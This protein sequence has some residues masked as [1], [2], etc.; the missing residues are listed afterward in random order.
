MRSLGTVTLRCDPVW[1]AI[2]GKCM[3]KN[4]F[5]LFPPTT[6]PATG[7][8]FSLDTFNKILAGV[9]DAVK[10]YIIGTAPGAAT[11]PAGTTSGGGSGTGA[12]SKKGQFD[13][14]AWLGKGSNALYALGVVFLL[15]LMLMVAK[16]K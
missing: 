1:T 2:S 5:P 12:P 16:E 10:R 9:D 7:K 13:P 11:P 8:A 6:D 15:L 4:G 3:D 14:F